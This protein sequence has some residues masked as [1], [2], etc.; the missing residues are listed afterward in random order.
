MIDIGITPIPKIETA[1]Q[2]NLSFSGQAT[3]DLKMASNDVMLDSEIISKLYLPIVA[4]CQGP[5]NLL[6]SKPETKKHR[7]AYKFGELYQFCEQ[8]IDRKPLKSENESENEDLVVKHDHTRTNEAEIST[9]NFQ[10]KIL[11][12]YV[13]EKINCESIE[14]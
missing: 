14:K 1:S 13:K 9:H 10:G 6:E 8:I 5:T 11:D 3:A 12:Y 7:P 2:T 4:T